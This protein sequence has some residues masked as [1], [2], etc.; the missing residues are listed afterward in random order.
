MS[1]GCA[2]SITA[3][4]SRTQWTWASWNRSWIQMRTQT[5]MS[6]M[7]F[8]GTQLTKMGLLAF[9]AK[10][11]NFCFDVGYVSSEPVELVTWCWTEEYF[12]IVFTMFSSSGRR[13]TMVALIVEKVL[14]TL[15][16]VG[17]EGKHQ[18][19]MRGLWW[20]GD[21]RLMLVNWQV[22]WFVYEFLLR[23]LEL[24]KSG[25][26][27]VPEFS[28]SWGWEPNHFPVHPAYKNSYLYGWF[29]F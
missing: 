23:S 14:P 17:V 19:A 8:D 28:V 29:A 1:K 5:L 13:L 22:I 11:W 6:W 21:S 9:P 7:L 2:G 15:W 25:L 10:Q 4:S 3:T 16:V 27:A 18:L 20:P 12:E 26:Q 24:F